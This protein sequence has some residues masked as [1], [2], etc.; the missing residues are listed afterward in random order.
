MIQ[1]ENLSIQ[2]GNRKLFDEL[3]LVV[4]SRDRV[5]LVGKN[6]AG[7]S[8]LLKIIKDLQRPDDGR[9]TM[10]N[11]TTIGYLPQDIESTST[12]TVYEETATAFAEINRLKEQFADYSRQLETATDY[13]SDDYYRLLERFSHTQER[14][15][16]LGATNM[17]A[18]AEKVLKGLGFENGQFDRPMNT[19]SGGWQMRVEL[20]KILLAQPDYILLDEPTNHLD[21]ESIIWLEKFLKD[22]AGGIV[23]ISHD[24]QFLDAVTNRTVEIVNGKVYDYAV[25]YS[26]FLELRDERREK[27]IN[28][29]KRQEK[30]VEHTEQLINKFRAKKN[31]AKFAQTLIRKLDRLEEIE[32]DELETGKIKF[33]FPPAPRSGLSV[34]KAENLDKSY[35]DLEVL[36]GV[37]FELERGQKV[38]FV[39]KNGEGKTTLTKIIL[40]KTPLTDGQCELGYNVEV[41]YYEQHQAE[42]LDGSKTVFETIDDLATGDLRSR[43][44]SLLGAFLFSGED[45]D[46]KVQVLSGGEKS[47]LALAK[48]LLQPFNLLILDEPTNHLDMRSKSILKQAIQNFEGSVI[49]VSHDREFLKDLTEKVYE[50]RN[51]NIDEHL[52]DISEFLRRRDID[53]MDELSLKKSYS[54]SEAKADPAAETDQ[55]EPQ[56]PVR[57]AAEERDFQK[58]VKRLRNKLNK[59]E[60]RVADLEAKKKQREAEMAAPAFYEQSP[61]EMTA[62][63]EAYETLKTELTTAEAEWEDVAFALE[64]LEEE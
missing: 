39:G 63:T 34:V 62:F 11:D 8:T 12:L 7:K 41:G 43:V 64:D 35:G 10:P 1:V 30:F 18:E 50:F 4:R 20:A 17:R 46:K 31:K 13:E 47:R 26:K 14:L 44:R 21:I 49:V 42:Q 29:K 54:E 24:Q 19:F 48:L 60:K 51:R 6:G 28:D 52:G 27:Q 3:T 33:T 15:Q 56:Q 16:Y 32:I 22:Y 5:G 57:S 38:A 40:G 55:A 53:S 61:D 2:Y 23:L 37:D 9:V 25:S 45:A 36:R 59:A 58:A